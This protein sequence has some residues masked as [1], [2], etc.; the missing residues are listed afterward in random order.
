MGKPSRRTLALASGHM[1]A[2]GDLT[3]GEMTRRAAAGDPEA[4]WL[5]AEFAQEIAGGLAPLL[6]GG[7]P[8]RFRNPAAEQVYALEQARTDAAQ[9]RAAEERAAVR[10]ERLN[11]AIGAMCLVV[12]IAGTIA[13]I[14][15]L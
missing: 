9:R 5:Q 6:D 2:D 8:P 11:I 4:L 12:G 14:V 7:N 10:R 3:L 13:A 1:S 15:A